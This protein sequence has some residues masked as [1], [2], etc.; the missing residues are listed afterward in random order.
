M[1]T[2]YNADG[3]ISG[4]AEQEYDALGNRTREISYDADGNVERRGWREWEYDEC[5]NCTKEIWYEP[6]GSIR[7]WKEYE[8]IT[9]AVISEE[10]LYD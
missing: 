7:Y 6:D 9:L 1:A 8:Y 10:N 4:W 3:S 5:G 2:Y